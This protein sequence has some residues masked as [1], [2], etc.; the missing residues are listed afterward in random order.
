MVGDDRDVLLGE[1]VDL[2]RRP[3]TMFL[4]FGSTITASAVHA[5]TASRICAVDGFIDCPPAT[6]VLH[7]EARE[8]AAHAVADADRDDRGRDG[9]RRGRRRR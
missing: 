3:G 4:L 2:A 9:R 8:Q 1:R 7:A 6:T 5:S